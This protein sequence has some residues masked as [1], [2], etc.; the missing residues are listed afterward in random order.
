MGP[1]FGNRRLLFAMAW[2][3]RSALRNA[4]T[5]AALF[6]G[7]TSLTFTP[8]RQMCEPWLPMYETSAT[9]FFR[10]SRE[11]VMFHCQLSGGLKFSSTAAKPVLVPT[12]ATLLFKPGLM[13]SRLRKVGSSVSFE[14]PA[15]PPLG[16]TFAVQGGLPERRRTSSITFE[17]LMKRPNPKRTA[18][19]PSP[20]TSQAR[21]TRG[22]KPLLY[23]CHS[24]RPNPAWPGFTKPL[25]GAVPSYNRGM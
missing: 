23:G 25:R 6:S 12:P 8:R 24:E 13:V 22:W 2:L 18:V 19:L 21:P 1:R 10:I 4:W 16:L 5:I 15:H 3:V 14:F 17:R 7:E 20:L 9:V 11:T